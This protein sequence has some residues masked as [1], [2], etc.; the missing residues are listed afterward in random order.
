MFQFSKIIY[1]LLIVTFIERF[2]HFLII[3]FLSIYLIQSFNYSSI[4][5]G[6]I[7]ST[8][9]VT[10]LIFS[11]ILAPLLGR[12]NKKKLYWSVFS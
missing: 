9:G 8:S 1:L 4:E 5:I 12:I 11:F 10:A 3:P 6:I 7:L 2:S